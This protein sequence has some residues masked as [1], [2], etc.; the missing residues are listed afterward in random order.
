VTSEAHEGSGA[1]DRRPRPQYGEYAPPGWVSPVAQPEAEPVDDPPP[2]PVPAP[3]AAA[4]QRAP[5]WDR[6]LTIGLLVVGLFGALIGWMIGATVVESLPLALEQYGVKPG[7]MPKW[8]D[9]AG[10]AL[11]ASHLLLYLLA[12][13]LSIALLRA[14]RPAFWAPLSAGVIAAIIFWSV[15]TAAI[16]PYVDQMQL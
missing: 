3:P 14:G 9:A 7:P 2:P 11:V 13:G 4:V 5:R 10:T 16:A 8:L 1:P 15:M 6:S 12:A